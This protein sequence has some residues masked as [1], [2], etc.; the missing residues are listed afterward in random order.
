MNG[1]EGY[2][3]GK[4]IEFNDCGRHHEDKDREG[5]RLLSGEAGPMGCFVRP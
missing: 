4:S 3:E 2:Q 1:V 5:S